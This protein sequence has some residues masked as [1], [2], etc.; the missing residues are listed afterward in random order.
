M[1][2]LARGRD[3]GSQEWDGGKGKGGV[4]G[5]ERTDGEEG[6]LRGDWP[7]RRRRKREIETVATSSSTN[8]IDA[9]QQFGRPRGKCGHIK[10]RTTSGRG[11]PQILKGFSH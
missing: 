9:K 11:N 7:K 2:G 10:A 4:G 8:Y 6:G 3:V 5:G 1:Q